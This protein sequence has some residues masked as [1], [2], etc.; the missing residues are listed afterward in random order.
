MGLENDVHS[1]CTLRVTGCRV[2]LGVDRVRLLA[3]P[4][5]RKGCPDG[6]YETAEDWTHLD[7][8]ANIIPGVIL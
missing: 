8:L 3:D 6:R 4:G 1:F 2:E 7:G 5:C